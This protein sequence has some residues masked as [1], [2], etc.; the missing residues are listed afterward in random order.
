MPRFLA[1]ESSGDGIEASLDALAELVLAHTYHLPH[2]HNL[3]IQKPYEC[4][5]HYEREEPD[6]RFLH[7]SSCRAAMWQ[8]SL[9]IYRRK[10]LRHAAEP[11][12]FN[13]CP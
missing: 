6:S 3:H 4:H 8:N 2:V 7:Y 12:M 1:F 13:D 10:P 11:Y 5:G 9:M